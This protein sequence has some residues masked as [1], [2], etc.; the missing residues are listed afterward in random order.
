MD[1][2]GRAMSEVETG[3]HIRVKRLGFYHHGIY[4]G[5]GRVVHLSGEVIEAFTEPERVEVIETS[6][7][8]FVSW[9]PE[10]E[11]LV[12]PDAYPAHVVCR[13]ARTRL[14]ERGYNLISRNCE[15]FATWC[16][17]GEWRSVQVEQAV[18]AM[19][20]AAIRQIKFPA[21]IRPKR[22]NDDLVSQSIEAL[23]QLFLG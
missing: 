19:A 23:T 15:H 1:D 10:V 2:G 11:V 8:E 6:L 18:F 12:Y 17:T 7:N 14:G 13:R 4:V 3:D 5:R 16:K 22:R 9:A 21:S 20:D